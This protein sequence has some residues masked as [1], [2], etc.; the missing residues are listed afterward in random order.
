MKRKITK[1]KV[2]EVLGW[3]FDDEGLITLDIDDINELVN[4]IEMIID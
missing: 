3:G 1:K 2:K 4:N